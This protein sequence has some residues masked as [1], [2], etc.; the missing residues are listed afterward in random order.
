[1]M[2]TNCL[3]DASQNI[4]NSVDHYSVSGGYQSNLAQDGGQHNIG[5]GNNESIKN[6]WH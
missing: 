3:N 2:L 4:S 6:R 1:M 5:G